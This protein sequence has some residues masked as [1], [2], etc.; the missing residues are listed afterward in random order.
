[1]PMSKTVFSQLFPLFLSVF[2][3]SAPASAQEFDQLLYD[4]D[5]KFPQ[6]KVHL[7]YD[8]PYYSPGE[9][10]W[11]KAYLISHGLPSQISKNLYADLI[12]EQGKIIESKF[13]P[14]INGGAAGAFE[15]PA[16]IRGEKVFVKAYTAWMLNFDSTLLYRKPIRILQPASGSKPVSVSTYQLDLFPE[17]GALINGISS[18][19]AF[20][21]YDQNGIP[22][23]VKG[24]IKD[25][26]GGTV[27]SFEAK[28][29]GMG[30]VDL[31]P[32]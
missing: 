13:M 9:T 11:F 19:L 4:Y 14:V 3:I 7:H 32:E 2:F 28:H 29:D 21:S 10:I 26:K 8:R 20:K 12:D 17:G 30:Y 25:G 23:A 18:R 5:Q 15:I 27:T 24:D 6:E 31:V 16:Y 1:Y 22:F